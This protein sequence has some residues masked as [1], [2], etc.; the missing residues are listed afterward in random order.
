MW[1][2][3]VASVPTG[4]FL[5]DGTNNTPDLRNRFVVGAGSTYNP[6]DTGGTT[7]AVVVSHTH[8]ASSV[9]T[10]PG[11]RHSYTAPSGTDTGGSFG[12]NVVDTTVSANTANAT[13][14]ITVATTVASAGVSGTN[15]N[16]PP[17]YALAYIMK[18]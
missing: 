17:Y 12:S 3:S 11:H 5:C 1:S 8:T 13:T 15:A 2:G 7:D 18:A 4:W 16:L 9:V 6:A 14:G 10:D